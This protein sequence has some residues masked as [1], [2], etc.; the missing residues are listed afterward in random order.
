MM[1]A[2]RPLPSAANFSSNFFS[3]DSALR[4]GDVRAEADHGFQRVDLVERADFAQ[5]EDGQGERAGGGAE[6]AGI[7]ADET[8]ARPQPPWI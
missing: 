8:H 7:H 6:I 1:D 2:T 3:E 5:V 4:G